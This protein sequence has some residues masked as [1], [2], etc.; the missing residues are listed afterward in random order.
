MSLKIVLKPIQTILKSGKC[1]IVK[2]VNILN[3][4]F[5]NNFCCHA[6]DLGKTHF[7]ILKVC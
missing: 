7:L 4:L 2:A 3:V 5:F 1:V 6:F